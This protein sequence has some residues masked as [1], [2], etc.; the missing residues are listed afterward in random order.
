MA[1]QINPNVRKIGTM[2]FMLQIAERIESE[3]R[4]HG[5]HEF[6]VRPISSDLLEVEVE[7]AFIEMRV[8]HIEHRA[9]RVMDGIPVPKRL[10]NP[11]VVVERLK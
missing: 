10:L 6:S 3:I 5:K 2:S 9:F 8:L 4:D 7:G 1:K 11:V